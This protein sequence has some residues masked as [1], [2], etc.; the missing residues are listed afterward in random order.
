MKRENSTVQLIN[1]LVKAA[2]MHRMLIM[3]L[4]LLKKKTDQRRIYYTLQENLPS[5][6]FTDPIRKSLRPAPLKTIEVSERGG[7]DIK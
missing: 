7:W 4:W 3:I 2:G 1:R 6:T 5:I